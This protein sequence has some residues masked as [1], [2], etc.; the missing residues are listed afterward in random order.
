MLTVCS[1][2]RCNM[3]RLQSIIIPG[4]CVGTIVQKQLG[5]LYSLKKYYT[6]QLRDVRMSVSLS[7]SFK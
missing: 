4:G 1:C 5:G 2:V 6:V 7:A 3:Q